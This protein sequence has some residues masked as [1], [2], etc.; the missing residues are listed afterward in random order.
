[1]IARQATRARGDWAEDR[2]LDFLLARGLRPVARNYRCRHGEID[3]VMRDGAVLVFAEVRYRRA[4][5]WVGGA[6]SV[7]ESKRRRLLASAAH[8]LQRLRGEVDPACRFDVV[9]VSGDDPTPV[10][11]WIRDAFEA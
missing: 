5:A 4:S 8:Y 7:G 9:S 11:D 1:L 2:A 6:E 10:I 3:L